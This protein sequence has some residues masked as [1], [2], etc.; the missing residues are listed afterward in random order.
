MLID[1]D[2]LR[3]T[4]QRELEALDRTRDELSGRVAR[5]KAATRGEWV[6]LDGHLDR[7]RHEIMRLGTDCSQ[8]IE[9]IEGTARRLMDEVRRGYVHMRHSL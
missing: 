5:A 3:A 2:R 4:L 8:S 6:R 1:A 9:A 7:A